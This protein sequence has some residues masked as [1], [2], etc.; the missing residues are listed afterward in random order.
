MDDLI[1]VDRKKNLSAEKKEQKLKKKQLKKEKKASKTH[2]NAALYNPD[3][4]AGSKPTIIIGYLLRF[5]SIGFSV[6]GVTAL[7]ADA[8]NIAPINYWLLL[9]Y[10]FVTVC[11]FSMIFLGKYLIFAGI[12]VLGLTAGA[13]YLLCG[14]PLTVFVSGIETVFNAIMKRLADMGFA[15][16]DDIYLYDFGG[17][18][19]KDEKAALM[20]GGLAAVAGVLGLIFAAFSARR[21]RLL[22]MLIFGGGLCV[23]CFT[24][25]LCNGNFGIAC[26]LAGLCSAIVLATYDKIYEKHKSSVKSRAFS[27]FSSALAGILCFA[28]V[29]IPAANIKN[30]WRDIP[31]I[32]D[33]MQD[34][35]TLLTTVLTGGNPKFNKMNSL[36]RKASAGIEDVVF[37]NVEL[38]TVSTSLK[39]QNVYLRSWIGSDY[40]YEN[41]NWAVM[42]DKD[43]LEFEKSSRKNLYGITGDIITSRLREL[44]DEELLSVPGENYLSRFNK[45]YYYTY[46]D[47]KYVNNNGLLYLVP[48][49]FKADNGLYKY[50]DVQ[51]GYKEHVDLYSDG[52]YSS[53]WLNLKKEYTT[54]AMIPTYLSAKYS[55]YMDGLKKY[56]DLTV[57]FI[58]NKL[59]NMKDRTEDYIIDTFES[60][61][62]AKGLEEY[63]TE[64]LE[65]YL[66]LDTSQRRKWV[67]DNIETVKLY[68]DFVH[69][70][71]TSYPEE[72]AGITEAKSKINESYSTAKTDYEKIMSVINYLVLNCDYS[73]T[74]KKPSGEYK[75][76][77]DA[78]ILE[79]NEGYCVQFATA[80]ALLLRSYGFPARYVQGYVATDFSKDIYN[81]SRYNSNVLDS[82]AHAWVEVWIDNVGWITLETTP[83]YYEKIYYIEREA[84]NNDNSSIY[85]KVHT[86]PVIEYTSDNNKQNEN[87][88]KEKQEET[89]VEEQGTNYTAL[90]LALSI[91]LL[92]I[93]LLAILI[94]LWIR[95]SRRI[96]ENRNYFIERAIYGN[97]E[98]ENDLLLVSGVITDTI[99]EVIS[100][101]GDKPIDG[102]SPAEFAKRVDNP[103][104]S[105]S[106]KSQIKQRS[107]MMWPSS[108]TEITKIIEKR[109]FGNKISR[110]E[111]SVIGEFADTLTKVEFR[112]LPLH[113]KIYY[114]YVK[115]MI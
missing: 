102:E 90:I 3:N 88:D 35:R 75:S 113:K 74:P 92:V 70:Y 58:L 97:F 71:Y 2:S 13:I 40:D 106:K 12:G 36:V 17:L 11:G 50:Q 93:V 85:D 46:V 86:D 101:R 8:F 6:F 31:L 94:I 62:N 81:D 21:T 22:P 112:T 91:S 33:G 55:E 5:F 10:C 114:R 110:D 104:L 108:F 28:I 39:N 60:T 95:R 64:I 45:G 1:I 79:T 63:G 115:N 109:E 76:D 66:S 69:S 103:P 48:S 42:S 43:Y 18:T 30:P 96:I 7:F 20:F 41:D 57:D 80:A 9:A 87:N 14:N 16:A 56:Y 44:Y 59:K 65:R 111:L 99:M 29:I 25:N 38:F 89:K 4:M 23:V 49:S 84:Q 52:I 24:Y 107:M 26:V 68:N 78:F 15:Y 54:S 77:L 67:E 83:K 27:G 47:V 32:S 19:A 34:A 100:I 37:E 73:L 53:S 72:S 98:E 105:K 82:N 51:T 61:L